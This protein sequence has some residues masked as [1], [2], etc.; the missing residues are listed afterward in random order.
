MRKR[1]SQA[2]LSRQSRQQ[3]STSEQTQKIGWMVD[4]VYT[5]KEDVAAN[6]AIEFNN[7]NDGDDN[8]ADDDDCYSKDVTKKM[9]KKGVRSKQT[10]PKKT[11]TKRNKIRRHINTI[12]IN[13]GEGDLLVE[14]DTDGKESDDD[15]DFFKEQRYD[16]TAATNWTTHADGLPGRINH[17]IPFTGPDELFRVNVSKKELKGMV[18]AHGDVRFAKISEWMLPTFD[19]KSFYEFLAA[20]MRN[21]MVHSIKTNGRTPK[22][23]N[24]A[25]KK[26]IAADHITHFYG[27]QLAGSLRCNLSIKRT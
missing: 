22:Y 24:P 27:C 16:K 18:D 20:R 6:K 26:D 5:H 2:S 7:R 13:H 10:T 23:H 17:P 19:T 14:G 15:I 3:D 25:N 21:K 12:T 11:T 4:N 1:I 8:D 9:R